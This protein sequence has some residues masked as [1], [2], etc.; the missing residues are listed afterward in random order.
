MN[1]T[2]ARARTS[3]VRRRPSRTSTSHSR[4]SMSSPSGSRSEAVRQFQQSADLRTERSRRRGIR[5]ER[6]S[7]KKRWCRSRRKQPKITRIAKPACSPHARTRQRKRNISD[8]AVKAAYFWGTE[9]KQAKGRRA[10]ILDREAIRLGRRQEVDLS[11]WK[12][13]AVIVASDGVVVTTLRAPRATRLRRC[14][15]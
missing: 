9:I 11:R 15:R 1:G 3:A 2:P 7:R 13:V 4:G 14:V 5:R 12:D 6:S 10:Y 8:Q